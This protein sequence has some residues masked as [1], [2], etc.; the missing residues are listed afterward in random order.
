MR[1]RV[2]ILQRVPFIMRHAIFH[3]VPIIT[4]VPVLCDRNSFAIE[5]D[6]FMKCKLYHSCV[7]C[8]GCNYYNTDDNFTDD[9]DYKKFVLVRADG[10]PENTLVENIESIEE[11]GK[12]IRML[13]SKSISQKVIMSLAYSPYNVLQF[14]LDLTKIGE[15]SELMH[16]AKKCGLLISL[17][18][19]PVIPT[20]VKASQ[21]LSIIDRYAF[22]VDFFCVRFFKKPVDCDYL[23]EFVSINDVMV[24]SRFLE[25]RE[26]HLVCSEDYINKFL[27][28]VNTYAKP[29]NLNIVLCDNGY[30]Y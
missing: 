30:C 10:V 28:L 8:S 19:S 29:R 21:V 25:L 24:P 1:Y 4:R 3:R 13:V 2:P 5:S 7:D 12:Y 17:Y 16:F 27:D 6:D 23:K 14:N 11:S 18:L 22:V 20:V 15:L 9:E 26:K